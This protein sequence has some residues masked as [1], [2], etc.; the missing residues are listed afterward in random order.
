[1]TIEPL[2]ANL[3]ESEFTT[4]IPDRSRDEMQ[5]DLRKQ[6]FE[7]FTPPGGS[8]PNSETGNQTGPDYT[9]S[10]GPGPPA[11]SAG[12]KR[13]VIDDL[14]VEMVDTVITILGGDFVEANGV[15]A[16][17]Y[18][19]PSAAGRYLGHREPGWCGA[20]TG[21]EI[22]D[23]GTISAICVDQ[24]QSLGSV[25]LDDGD[26]TWASPTGDVIPDDSPPGDGR[27]INPFVTK[28]TWILTEH[29]P[30]QVLHLHP[31]DDTA[32]Q[33][34]SRGPPTD[35]DI[36]VHSPQLGEFSMVFV[37]DAPPA[38]ATALES[39]P[40]TDAINPPTEQVD[41]EKWSLN[42]DGFDVTLEHL[43]S[44]G[45]QIAVSQVVEER[46]LPA[47]FIHEDTPPR[48]WTDKVPP[49]Q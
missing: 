5:Y 22:E 8:S 30:E 46:Y 36:F 13:H 6:L 26:P 43:L 39:V 12:F 7:H 45:H 41:E 24:M 44:E 19:P 20:I 31:T 42:E 18:T 38:A 49:F 34:A 48:P 14:A 23:D 27:W 29:C 2:F 21:V 9:G 10:A 47:K 37:A 35:A 4:T 33:R 25:L 11:K 32:D 17:F 28:D 15:P 16:V 40:P 3:V 1:M